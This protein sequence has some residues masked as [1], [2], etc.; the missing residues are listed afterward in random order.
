MNSTKRWPQSSR[1]KSRYLFLF[2]TYFVSL[3]SLF[4]QILHQ[5]LN[6]KDNQ[7]SHFRSQYES[8]MDDMRIKSERI[9]DLEFELL[10]AKQGAL[11]FSTQDE[12][13]KKACEEKDARI[14]Q[15]EAE[16]NRR[17]CD[18]QSIVNNELWEKNRSITKMQNALEHKDSQLC[19]LKNK[20][21]E[22]G[23]NVSEEPANLLGELEK[24]LNHLRGEEKR[25]KSLLETS[26]KVKIE[27]QE[28]IAILSNRLEE[29]CYFLNSL[30]KQKVVLGFLG[31]EQ[32]KRLRKAVDVSLNLSQTLSANITLG[33][34]QSLLQLS[35]I[36]AL[37]NV[38]NQ[39]ALF[40]EE[41]N[42]EFSI[43]PS[44]VTLTYNYRWQS[45]SADATNKVSEVSILC[46]N[47]CNS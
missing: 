17:N 2:F 47:M 16:L 3:N 1:I 45:S 31:C 19:I 44:D 29:L 35:D 39:D 25:L 7:L 36:S 14:A 22:L 33:A 37:L 13:Q 46:F 38:S 30:L 21:S 18:L 4:S 23:T 5:T 42:V 26:D 28:L 27:N 34:D 11:P 32:A 15:L 6:E 10:A 24:E 40:S 41:K 9:V 43:V 20:I 8:A 12:E